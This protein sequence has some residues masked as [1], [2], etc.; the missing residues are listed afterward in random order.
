MDQH[1][2]AHGRSV[3][4]DLRLPARSRRVTAA[5]A[6]LDPVGRGGMVNGCTFVEVGA[7]VKGLFSNVMLNAAFLSIMEHS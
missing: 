2:E 3:K 1:H 7:L 4:P 5:R 6:T